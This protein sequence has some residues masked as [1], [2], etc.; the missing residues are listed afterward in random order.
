[1][2]C[3][4]KE[5]HIVGLRLTFDIWNCTEEPTYLDRAGF[6]DFTF[7]LTTIKCNVKINR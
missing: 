1:M 6:V 5:M 2:T 7:T 3:F 4:K